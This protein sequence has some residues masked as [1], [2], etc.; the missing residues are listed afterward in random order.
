MPCQQY[1][2][3]D[4]VLTKEIA[5]IGHGPLKATDDLKAFEHDIQAFSILSN[6]LALESAFQPPKDLLFPAL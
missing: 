2:H 3:S 6:I 1:F 5:L 4:H